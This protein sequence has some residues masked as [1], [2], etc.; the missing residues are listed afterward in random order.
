MEQKG[1]FNFE[2]VKDL[3]LNK[4]EDLNTLRR[5]ISS[6]AAE[7]AADARNAATSAE[8]TSAGMVKKSLYKLAN[9]LDNIVETTMPKSAYKKL[10]DI[11][12]RYSKIIHPFREQPFLKQAIDRHGNITAKNV[13]KELND[14]GNPALM[15]NLLE[16]EG[17]LES[18]TKH[19]LMGID[20]GKP[21]VISDLLNSDQG[22]SLPLK[23]RQQLEAQVRNL[24]DA[25]TFK[26]FKGQ[27][28]AS[29]L[30]SLMNE[31][32]MK[33]IFKKNPDLLKRLGDIATTREAITEIGFEL[34]Q[35][36]LDKEQVKIKMDKLDK[37][38]MKG[39]IQGILGA[40]AIGKIFK[41]VG[42]AFI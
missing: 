25:E 8:R 2:S 17:F 32:T 24:N 35:L 11:D 9:Y 6:E 12:A 16:H 31:P 19:D 13:F 27:I 1:F 42:G 23:V 5:H 38:L 37:T 21:K 40:T 3:N 28:L 41:A 10:K 34:K 4:L 30:K 33:R 22:R 26:T 18:M 7:Y 14:L 29:E 15:K 36:G 39:R 20:A